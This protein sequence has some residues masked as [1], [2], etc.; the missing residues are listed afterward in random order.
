MGKFFAISGR[1]FEAYFIVLL[2]STTNCDGDASISLTVIFLPNPI[3]P[4]RS[5]KLHVS[6]IHLLTYTQTSKPPDT[7]A[8][9]AINHLL[10][11][12]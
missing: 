4:T 7:S 11:G 12:M 5:Y 10:D 3:S 9:T 6:Q 1:S 8:S 2:V